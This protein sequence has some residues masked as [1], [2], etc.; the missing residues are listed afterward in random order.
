MLATFAAKVCGE[1]GSAKII[2]KMIEHEDLRLNFRRHIVKVI[3]S[4]KKRTKEHHLDVSDRILCALYDKQHFSDAVLLLQRCS[5][6]VIQTDVPKLRDHFEHGSWENLA[7][8]YPG[9]VLSSFRLQLEEKAMSPGA[10]QQV[11]HQYSSAMKFLVRHDANESVDI[12]RII[13]WCLS[14]YGLSSEKGSN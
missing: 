10:F 3:L 13:I 11:W 8:S 2:L 7:R 5:F 6:E 14:R 9:I 12:R 1:I 4:S